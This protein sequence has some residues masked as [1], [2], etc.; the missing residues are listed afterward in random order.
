MEKLKQ[1]EGLLTNID[2][3]PSIPFKCPNGDF[4]CEYVNTMTATLDIDCDKCD[5]N[6]KN[7]N[8]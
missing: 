5:I 7:K 1:N 3:Y 8:K 6:P 2:V 4:S